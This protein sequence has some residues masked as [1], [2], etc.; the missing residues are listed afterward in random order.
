MKWTLTPPALPASSQAP[1]EG[2]SVVKVWDAATGAELRTVTR[3]E[4]AQAL[5]WDSTGQRLFVAGR[6]GIAVWDPDAVTH[7]LTL[8]TTAE[9]LWWAPGGKDLV[10]VGP[11]GPRAW[12]TGG[13]DP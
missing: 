2:E 11:N 9:R 13:R 12:E 6:D 1:V 7:F 8:K 5:L 3:A 10:S 4:G